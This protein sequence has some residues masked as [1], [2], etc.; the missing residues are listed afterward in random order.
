M[1]PWEHLLPNPANV[2]LDWNH[3]YGERIDKI[4]AADA[5]VALPG[6]VGT[7]AEWT[8]AWMSIQTENQPRVLV[9][10]GER[11]SNL[12]SRLSG[13]LFAEQKDYALLEFADEPDEI[14]DRI[15]GGLSRDASPLARG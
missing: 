9:L 1:R 13:V 7:L 8:L 10:V 2:E 14:V 3:S 5:V 6:G 15:L 12:V 11:W 4:A